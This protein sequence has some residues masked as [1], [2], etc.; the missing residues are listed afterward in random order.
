M[1]SL[2]DSQ[3]ILPPADY[4]RKFFDEDIMSH[5]VYHSNLYAIQSNPSNPLLLSDLEFAQFLGIV[6][7]MSVI[8]LPRSRL[9]WSTQLG[10]NQ[11]S[12]VMGRN[13]FEQI[14]AFVHFNDNTNMAPP[15]SDNFDRLFK[16]RPLLSHLQQKY[17]AIPMDQMVCIDEQMI[18]FKGSSSLK[19]YVP[20]KP[21]K[22]GYKV[23]VLCD[24]KGIIY[25]FQIYTG[26]ISSPKNFPDLGAS[27]NIVLTLS[28][29]IPQ[30]KNYLLYFDNWFTSYPLVCEL[31][32]RKIYCLGTVRTNRLR[33]CNLLQ[34][35]ELKRNGRGSF[36][37][38][39][40]KNGRTTIRAI[41]WYDS[42][43]VT[44]L[45]SF[46]SAYPVETVQRW[47]KSSKSK[48]DIPCPKVVQTYNKFMGG[49]DLLDSLIGLYRIKLRSK[50]FYHR[51][52]FH[53]LDVS[54][55]TSWLLYT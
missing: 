40:S 36:D 10:I 9:Y 23:F 31:A 22:Y 43:A 20:S 3:T 49:V 15:G 16:I 38:K 50:K 32:K 30:N 2:P 52:F 48:T 35:K 5:I 46:E 18:P 26:K 27:S 17:N 47:D 21:H 45:T 28:T 11:I 4:F 19:Q 24:S 33:G 8:S 53:F 54:V 13:R 44:F 55:V 42:K 39:E 12:S 51:I 34:D 1:G 6:M 25:D 37:E 29:V 41:K 7:K 14:K